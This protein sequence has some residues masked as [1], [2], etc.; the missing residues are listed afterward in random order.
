MNG[1]L[2]LYGLW[3]GIFSV[4]NGQTENL[5]VVGLIVVATLAT[6]GLL[7]RDE[8][9]RGASAVGAALGLTL[10]FVG[11]GPPLPSLVLPWGYLAVMGWG[12]LATFVPAVPG[13]LL[14]SRS[15]PALPK[16][17][18]LSPTHQAQMKK[19]ERAE[20]RKSLFGQS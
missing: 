10:V 13:E 12:L 1:L 5:V 11:I 6:L 7:L 3:L 18:A 9:D 2:A 8:N 4:Q 19:V 17:P 16:S 15:G 14:W 20:R